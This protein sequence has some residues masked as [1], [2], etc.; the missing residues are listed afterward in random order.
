MPIQILELVKR[1][2]EQRYSDFLHAL[3][4]KVDSDRIFTDS[5]RTFAWGTDASFYRQIPK[6]VIISANEEE[7][8]LIL[9]TASD[10]GVP[11][12]FRAAGTALSGQSVTDSV[13]VVAGKR[14]EGLKTGPRAETV[15]LQPGL[16][17][18]HVNATLA[19]YG[20]KLGPDPASI[21]SAMIGGIVMNN[22][23]G[24]SCGVHSNSDRT[25]VSARIVLADGTVLDTGDKASR[26]RF[27]VTHPGFISAIEHLRDEVL[28]DNGLTD[29]IKYKY[30]IKNVTGLNLLPLVTYE[31]PFEIIAH[32]IVGSEGTLAFLS[33][34]TMRTLPVAPLQASAM[35]YFRDIKDAAC[36]VVAMRSLDISAAEMLDS[37]SLASARDT[38]WV[39]TAVRLP[40]LAVSPAAVQFS[41]VVS[42]TEARERESSI[43]AA[44]ISR[45]RIATTARA[46]SFMSRKYIIALA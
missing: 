38:T 16:V 37:R 30:S 44:V 2:M 46:A 10:Y 19:K 33:E 1:P 9:K 43:S 28:A 14:W 23:S 27:R 8:A 6:I 26:E 11:V 42:R 15:S 29:R 3:R 41:H 24:M 35:I 4:T 25:M 20:R 7:V 32:S 18:G 21:G 34:V 12:T 13:L 31:D 5:L 39:R 22:A 36:A 40:P 45:L 17:G